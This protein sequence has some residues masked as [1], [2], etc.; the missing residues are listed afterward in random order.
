MLIPLTTDRPRSKS[1]VLVYSLIAVNTLIFLGMLMLDR[2]GGYAAEDVY[3][4]FAVANEGFVWYQLISSA[5]LHGGWMHIIGNMIVL[6][7]LGPNV[8][9]KMGHAGFGLLYLVS[10]VASGLAHILF[11]DNPAVGASGAIAGITGAYLVLFPKTRIICFVIFFV[12]GRIA[13]PAW[14]FIGLSI[15]IDL[16]ANGLGNNTGV[17]HAAHL[18]GY[19]FGI[20]TALILL[21][22][23]VLKREPYDLFT[24]LKQ[25][26]RRA[27]F[28]S[29]AKLHEQTIQKKVGAQVPESPRQKAINA[30]R[31]TIGELVSLGKLDDAAD[32]YRVFVDEFGTEDTGTSLSRDLQLKLAEHLVRTDDR[33]TAVLAY[34]AFARAFP[35]DRETPISLLMAALMLIRNLGKPEEAKPLLE[36]ALPRLMGEEKSLADELMRE[37]G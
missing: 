3:R 30:A 22:T 19:F 2:S 4:R 21:W 36:K 14:W 33:A 15:C 18:G 10:A 16:F 25:K 26:K 24:V 23:H 7:A 1:P 32:K 11:S 31:M 27:E 37:V 12:I 34:Q 29:A 5:F 9:D 13:V 35:M 20:M 8:E 6:A 17:A 28:A